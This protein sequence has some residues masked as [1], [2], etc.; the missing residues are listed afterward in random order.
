MRTTIAILVFGVL[1]YVHTAHASPRA[2][3][4][5]SEQPSSEN[6]WSIDLRRGGSNYIAF[7]V[8]DFRDPCRGG[9]TREL[10]W[11][12]FRIDLEYDILRKEQRPQRG[13]WYLTF[14][15]R[16]LSFWDVFSLSPGAE[17]A[18]FIETN[19]SPGLEV[20]WAATPEVISSS[21]RYRMLFTLG[22]R[23]ESNGLGMTKMLD[24]GLASRSWNQ[25]YGA[26][27][28]IAKLSKKF[29]LYN[30]VEAWPVV[31][32]SDPVAAWGGRRLEDYV[33]YFQLHEELRMQLGGLKNFTFTADIRERSLQLEARWN[34]KG[35]RFI[36][37]GTD[38][39][40]NAPA[41]KAK[42]TYPMTAQAR[43]QADALPKDEPGDA[44][45]PE[46]EQCEGKRRTNDEVVEDN[47]FR[48]DL[49]AQC[50]FG[51]GERLI[52]ADRRSES[53]YVGL[54]F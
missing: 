19:Y 52:V 9:E 14:P 30:R 51:K 35:Q 3:E 16:F 38:P 12:K 18:P 44:V 4:L 43:R 33:G 11:A 46:S 1:S 15:I 5:S 10:G 8:C 29:Q 36:N 39:A 6:G 17:S 49:F 21:K 27:V 47:F 45:V 54:G 24:L 31:L 32:W 22:V 40:Q 28:L 20:T 7:N 37:H 50:F 23:H 34:I 42:D 41:C 13:Y 53:C 2:Y 26:A 25:I 48:L